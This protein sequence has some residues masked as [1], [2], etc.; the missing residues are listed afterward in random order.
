[1]IRAFLFDIGNVILR[2]DFSKAARKIAA[3]SEVADPVEAMGLLD[4]IKNMYEDGQIDRASFLR[5]AFDAIRY[6][7]TEEEFVSA[8]QDIF[9]L[10]EPMA[11][12]VAAI[13]PRYPLFLLSNTSDIHVE[14]FTR[15]YPVFAAFRGGTYSHEA[16]T[17]KPGEQI[18]RVAC[19]QHGLEPATTFFID[20]L[21]PNIETGRRLGFQAHHYHH[22]KHS[23]LTGELG[24]VG[25][26]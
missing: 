19:E 18:Y 11:E 17:S 5:G 21:L 13:A 24:R 25:V 26:L 3:R 7:G 22:E 1:M 4:Q 10:N 14:F 15:R 12:L 16:R 20:D 23:A 9:E 2:F 8:W 6:R